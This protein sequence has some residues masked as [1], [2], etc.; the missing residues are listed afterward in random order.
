M[1]SRRSL[2]SALSAITAAV[3]GVILNLA[4]WFSLHTLFSQVVKWHGFGFKVD[5][6]V[7]ASIN[8]PATVL[9]LAAMV[10]MFR[11][12]VGMLPTM[13]TCSLAGILYYYFA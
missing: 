7:L 13:A 4:V 8:L 12:K 9:S 1:F 2:P 5:V 6:P 3:V 11:F 10:A